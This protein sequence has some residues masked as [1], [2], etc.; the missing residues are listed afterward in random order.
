MVKNPPANAGDKGS[1]PGSGSSLEE[2]IATHSSIF[3]WRIAWTEDPGGLWSIG[4]KESDTTE[5]TAHTH[6]F[7]SVSCFGF[8]AAQH[9]GS[10][11]PG[12]RLGP[13]PLH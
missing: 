8:L 11:L 1:I 3:A 5:V 12:L 9:V 2:G 13:L 4:S 10:Q 7:A 6:V